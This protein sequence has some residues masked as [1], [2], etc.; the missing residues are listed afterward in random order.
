VTTFKVSTE[1]L[2]SLASQ[3]SRLVGEL[4][5][6]GQLTP[7]YGVA[8]HPHVE[9]SLKSF[10]DDWSDGLHQIEQHLSELTQRLSSAGAHYDGTDQTLAG[11]FWPV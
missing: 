9:S 7:D 6:A 11:E 5:Q 2:G 1:E 4:G 3:L 10:F 8:G